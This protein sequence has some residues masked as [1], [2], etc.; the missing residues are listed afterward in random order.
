MN[1]ERQQ[2]ESVDLAVPISLGEHVVGLPTAKVTL[3]EY[4]DF[5]CRF[6]EQAHLVVKALQV[7]FGLELRFAFR[8]NPRGELHPHARLAAQACEAAALQGG[9]WGMHDT[10]FA[11]PKALEEKDLIG[12]AK[13]LGLDAARFSRELHSLEVAKHVRDD[14]LGGVRS[15]IISTPTFFINGARFTGSPDL[16]SLSAAIARASCST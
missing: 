13:V 1:T 6:C 8:H 9:F 12:Y 5:G 15:N 2:T 11:N 14:E 4:G 7:R 3:V 10:L 16:E